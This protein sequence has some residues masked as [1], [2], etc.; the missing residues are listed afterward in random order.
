MNYKKIKEN[1]FTVHL[2]NYERFKT[3]NIDVYFTS[4]FNQ[5]DIPF[6]NLLVK[7]LAFSTKKYN[8]KNKIAVQSE[9]LYSATITSKHMVIGNIQT[10]LINLE[11]INPSFT[12]ESM[13]KE[14][15]DF[16]KEV[17]FNPN[18]N[19][20]EFEKES[21]E[22]NKENIIREIKAVKEKPN[23]IA[24]ENFS[25]EMY[26]GS[27][28]SYSLFGKS[29]DYENITSKDLYKFYKK[30]INNSK[31]DVVIMGDIDEDKVLD[32]TKRMLKNVETNYEEI[33]DIYVKPKIKEKTLVSKNKFNFNQSILI[34]GYKFSSLS[35]YEL[36]Y[37]LSIFNIILGTM[38][39]S[40]LFTKVREESSYCYSVSSYVSK[41]NPSLVITSGI[42]R[43]NYDNVVKKIKECINLMKDE[44]FITS[45]FKTAIK[46]ANIYLND[47]YDNIY[48]IMEHYYINEF[49]TEEEVEKRREEYNKMTPK[50]ICTLAKKIKLDTIYFME[51]IYENN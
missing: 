34:M 37:V 28:G 18:V 36:K 49:D 16:L 8:T 42:N 5:K 33:K 20:E 2:I 40:V 31:I 38:N 15:F 45:L 10:T 47:Y 4:L 7:M 26:K 6:T 32:L 44:K 13:Y 9:N 29:E 12:E 17:I 51:G 14:S 1:N 22:L 25:K 19:E 48:S 24:F 21:F 3:I 30:L 23:L 27:S 50:D 46:T 41:Y 43:K 35:D 11:F 39:N